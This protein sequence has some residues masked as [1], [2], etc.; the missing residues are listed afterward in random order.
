MQINLRR[1]FQNLWP[2]LGEIHYEISAHN[3]PQY[4]LVSWKIEAEDMFL[5]WKYIKRYW[6][7]V[8]N[9]MEA[10]LQ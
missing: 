3:I 10:I 7:T 5:L 9:L 6:S 4:F 8:E 1:Y 2:G